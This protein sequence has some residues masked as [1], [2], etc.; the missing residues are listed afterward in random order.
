MSI[1]L[2]PS[3]GS[4]P[5]AAASCTNRSATVRLRVSAAATA[6]PGSTL[7]ATSCAALRP[8]AGQE[9]LA[10]QAGASG[11]HAFDDRLPAGQ[12][13]RLHLVADAGGDASFQSER[14][15]RPL[16]PVTGHGMHTR[17][18]GGVAVAMP[19]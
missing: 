18:A 15:P 8:A 10:Q 7:A 3:T 12:R 14:T 13:A 11:D 19:R 16:S 1:F 17:P 9:R 4:T 6:A 5:P 2:A